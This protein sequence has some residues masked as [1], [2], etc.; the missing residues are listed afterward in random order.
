MS[1]TRTYTVTV[2]GG[3]PSNHPYHNFGSSNKY[4]IDGSTAT[5]D[6]TLYIAESGTFKF[7]QS[8]S[9]NGGHPLR[10]STT[11]NGTHGGG[12]EYTTGVTTNGTP[13]QAGAYTQITV[14][15]D[16]PTLYYYCTNHS[17]MGWTANTP[18]ADT[19]GALGWSSNLWGTNE[20]FTSGWGAD[21]W[22][23]GG[24]WGQANDEVVQL[25]GQAITST[26]GTLISG[27]EQGWGR[28]GWSEEPYGDSFSPVISVDGFS[29]TSSL[30][31]AV[32]FPEQGWGR[33]TWNFESW[34]FS[35]LTV[36]LSGFE[37][38]SDLGANGWS[39]ASY[40]DNGWGMFTIN[41]ADAVGLTGQEITSAVPSQLDIPE[42]ISGV[43]M[44]SSV[45]AI[46]PLEQIVG[47][48]GQAT[49]STIGSV[50]FDLTSVI[51]PTGQ[52]ITSSVGSTIEGTVEFI[53]VTGVEATFS[54]GSVDLGEFNVGLTG[55][56]ATFSVGSLVPA[57]VMGLT[58]Q[59]ITSSVAGFGTASGFGIQAYSD[60]DT[61]S[62][63]SYTN[64]A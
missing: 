19:W 51:S 18:A 48:S 15:D 3:N 60:V 50:T 5:A 61:G 1:V 64:V 20:E 62:N 57:D 14:A 46:V 17:G 37:I 34:G 25:S 29:I 22:D 47:L 63:T 12:S 43:S 30:G 41:P 31:D 26:L 44:T 40:G 42:Q 28:D 11:A 38:T 59:E 35:G 24:S 13:G 45:G 4:A 58:G 7:D 53:P 36:E 52:G 9:S 2:V 33:D 6:V 32:A 49:T 54:I 27:A 16:A 8:D 56:S 39:N 21:A 55:Q 10:F 23:T